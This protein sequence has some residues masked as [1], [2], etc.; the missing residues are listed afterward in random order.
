MNPQIRF[1]EDLMS[2]VSYIMMN[3][4]GE[5]ELTKWCASAIND[6]LADVAAKA[7]SNSTRWLN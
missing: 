2:R 6:L 5:T 4:G 3:P 1:G 7:K